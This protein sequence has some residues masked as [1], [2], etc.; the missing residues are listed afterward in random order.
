MSNMKKII[1]L[2]I[3]FGLF[4]CK[5]SESNKSDS[6]YADEMVLVVNYELENMTLEEHAALGKAVAPNFNSEEIPGFIGKSFVGALE[7]EVFGGIYYF[8][9]DESVENFLESEIWK[10][11]VAHPNL[12]NFST[13]IYNAF[14]GTEQANGLHAPRKKSNDVDD[15][16]GL[17]VLV[18]NYNYVEPPSD[19]KMSSDVKQYAPVFSNENFPGM[20]GKT[21]I[22]NRDKKIYGGV[23]YFTS[24]DAID[25]YFESELWTAFE[26]D[27]NTD[28]YMK[29]I[30]AVASISAISNGVPVL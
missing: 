8:S 11:V 14:D 4:A 19:E 27:E 3:F 18:V 24:R 26:G 16:E 23:Y 5:S 25:S 22:N 1:S 17:H 9:G 21:M 7:R 6:I 20:I 13:K 10:G 30:Y 28:V 29:D 2:A 12:V 15:A